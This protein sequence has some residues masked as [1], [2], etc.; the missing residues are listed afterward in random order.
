MVCAAVAA[1]FDCADHLLCALLPCIC[2][3]LFSQ[4]LQAEQLR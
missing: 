4:Q 2:C 1:V 3:T